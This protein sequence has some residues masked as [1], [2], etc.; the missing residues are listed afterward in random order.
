MVS[1]GDIVVSVGGT[2]ASV[3]SVEG[4][5]GRDSMWGHASPGHAERWGREGAPHCV[6]G[7][8]LGGALCERVW[9]GWADNNTI[10]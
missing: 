7:T 3:E 1:V 2:V 10:I 8:P 9:V 4:C 5:S 6:S